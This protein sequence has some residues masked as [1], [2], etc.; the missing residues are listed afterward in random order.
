MGEEKTYIS[1]HEDRA[2]VPEVAPLPRASTSLFHPVIRYLIVNCVQ[3]VD[4]IECSFPQYRGDAWDPSFYGSLVYTGLTLS[5]SKDSSGE[6]FRGVNVNW[7]KKQK[8]KLVLK[9][10][11]H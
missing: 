4:V 8:T 11:L 2:S 10:K 9:T 7:E 1:T 5:C 3:V 6:Y